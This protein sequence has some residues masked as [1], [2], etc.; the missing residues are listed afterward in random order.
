MVIHFSVT[1]VAELF[2]TYDYKQLITA[3]EDHFNES[4]KIQ[5]ITTTGTAYY[6]PGRNDGVVEFH[7]TSDY[8]YLQDLQLAYGVDFITVKFK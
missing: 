3:V 7:D 5:G 8:I 2:T 4:A 6:N 1:E